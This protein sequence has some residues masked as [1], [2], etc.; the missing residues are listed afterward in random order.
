MVG[1]PKGGLMQPKAPLLPCF[2][3]SSASAKMW[4]L[5]GARLCSAGSGLLSAFFGSCYFYLDFS[6][7]VTPLERSYCTELSGVAV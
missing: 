6:L 7:L 1:N 5:L 2:L 3:P 4:R